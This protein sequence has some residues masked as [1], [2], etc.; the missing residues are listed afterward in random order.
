MSEIGGPPVRPWEAAVLAH[1]EEPI[2][3]EVAEAGTQVVTDVLAATVAG[4]SVPS[5]RTVHETA[6]LPAGDAPVLGT[7]T[8]TSLPF[9]AMLNTTAAIAVEI[10]EGHNRGG[11]VGASLIAGSVAAADQQGLDGRTYVDHC[12]RVYEVCVRLEEAIFAMKDRLNEA[13]PWVLRDPHATWTVVGPALTTALCLGA[14]AHQRKET[15]RIA[16]NLAVISMFD[17]YAEGAPARNFTAG[18]SA[19]AGVTAA[20]TALGGLEGS[21]AAM[22]AVYDPFDEMGVGFAEMFEELG[23]RWEVTKAYHKP[24]P[25]CRYTHPPLD[26]LR[27]AVS[28]SAIDPATVERM[29][30][31]TFSNAAEMDHTDPQT[32]TGGKFST[33]YVLSRYLWDG[34]LTH[35]HFTEEAVRDERLRPLMRRVDLRADPEYDARFPTEWGAAVTIELRDGREL[36][37]RCRYPRGDHRNP[38]SPEDRRERDLEL[39]QLSLPAPADALAALQAL[40]QT[41]VPTTVEAL[42]RR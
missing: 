13:V 5:L 35:T 17:P 2:P 29:T 18:M 7:A 6:A 19:Q 28:D 22:R 27:D 41:P 9:A 14:D 42:C 16:A 34:E 11:H 24:V 25:S 37:G 31:H 32:M 8:A 4:A 40:A 39:L 33:P 38:L 10:E 1:L 36:V 15:F 26:A 30:V 3:P 12:I 21:P 23:T 20:I